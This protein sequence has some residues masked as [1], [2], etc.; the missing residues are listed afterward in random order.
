MFRKE[1]NY[2]HNTI[3][4]VGVGIATTALLVLSSA[5]AA[6]ASDNVFLGGNGAFSDNTAHVSN[7]NSSSVSQNNNTS[8]S[9]DVSNR[10]STGG[11]SASFNT[12][13]SVTI[14]TGDAS[15]TTGISNAAGSNVAELS[16]SC[17]CTSGGAN[18]AVS[19]N[20]AFSSNNVTTS[21]WNR[22]SFIQS[23]RDYFRNE[24]TNNLSTGHN[25]SDFNTGT[26]VTIVSGGANANTWLQ[27]QAGSNV[28][29]H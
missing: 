29:S 18:V 26:D 1:V 5:P 12:G 17:G 25:S 11:N 21:N 4:K 8:I 23:N 19:G 9:N 13:G 7:S 27:N 16:N 20:G 10:A 28:L 24:V 2:M 15:S 22:E 14:Y 3:R 6:F